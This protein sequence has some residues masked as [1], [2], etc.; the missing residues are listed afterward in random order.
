MVAHFIL[1]LY[2]ALNQQIEVDFSGLVL[3]TCC[4]LGVPISFAT[5]VLLYFQNNVFFRF[6]T[7]LET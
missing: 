1:H 4:L 2:K 5:G 7:I 3:R 6:K